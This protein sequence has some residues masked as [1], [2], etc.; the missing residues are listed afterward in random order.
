ME[1][2]A[3]IAEKRSSFHFD[4]TVDRFDGAIYRHGEGFLVRCSSQRAGYL[5]LF[6][7][8]VDGEPGLL[9]PRA[10]DDPRIAANEVVNVPGGGGA[11]PVTGSPGIARI[12]AI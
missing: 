4:A 9:Y 12:T 1:L 2:V 3:L 11:F 10:G 8:D 6:Y 5:Y 7:I